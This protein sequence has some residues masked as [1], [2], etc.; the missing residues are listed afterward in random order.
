MLHYNNSSIFR[1]LCDL[2]RA[3][4]FVIDQKTVNG[5]NKVYI[6]NI[7]TDGSKDL[8]GT[9]RDSEKA[10]VDWFSI[11]K[12]FLLIESLENNLKEINEESVIKS[13]M[14]D[15]IISCS[16]LINDAC[17][18]ITDSLSMKA[19]APALIHVGVDELQSKLIAMID[20]VY[21]FVST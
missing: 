1:T 4:I 16:T 12:I 15:F 5:K 14:N 21:G 10:F 18:D 7:Q 3:G 20:G 11:A 13:R 9:G 17:I 19:L 2:E 6:P 8:F